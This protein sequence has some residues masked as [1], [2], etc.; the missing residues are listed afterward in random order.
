MS[1]WSDLL[2]YGV[3]GFVVLLGLVLSGFSRGAKRHNWHEVDSAHVA[4]LVRNRKGRT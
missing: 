4:M 1:D 3:Y 2:V